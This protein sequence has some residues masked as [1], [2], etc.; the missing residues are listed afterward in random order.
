MEGDG[1]AFALPLVA[2]PEFEE[3]DGPAFE[4][5]LAVFGVNDTDDFEDGGGAFFV[6]DGGPFHSIED[7]VGHE[8]GFVGLLVGLGPELGGG[9]LI[10]DGGEGGD[11]AG[12]GEAGGFHPAEPRAEVVFV[13]AR[14][15]AEAAGGIAVHGGVSNGSFGAIGGGEEEGVTKVGK[16]PDAG[17]ADAGLDILAGDV[18]FFPGELTAKYGFDRP[19]VGFDE[20][21]DFPLGV[22]A[23]EGFGDGA[24]GLA[25][26]VATV[27]GALVGAEEEELH[28][29]VC[30]LGK[31][32]VGKAFANLGFTKFCEGEVEH[33]FGEAGDGRGVGTAT[34]GDDEA[35]GPGFAKVV[36]VG[37]GH[38]AGEFLVLGHGRDGLVAIPAGDLG[39]VEI[40][41]D[42]GEAADVDLAAHGAGLVEAVAFDIDGA[43]RESGF[44]E[45]EAGAFGD[46]ASG[47]GDESAA[48]VDGAS[49]FVAEEVGVNVGGT[50]SAGAF[51]NELFADFLF[52]EGEVGGAGV[53]DD[54]DSAAG[55][56][57]AGAVGDP[58]V[59]TDFEANADAADFENGISDGEVVI[60]E[61][62]LDDDAFGPGVEPTGFVV[63]AVSC[64]VFLSDETADGAIDKDGDGVVN[65]VFDPDREADG[66]DHALGFW[67]DLSEAGPSALG[68]FVGEELVL[69]AIAGD[70]EFGQA[71]DG[72]V[73]FAGVGDALK[74]AAAVA[75]PVHGNLVEAACAYSDGVSHG[76]G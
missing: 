4:L 59:F 20:G 56:E 51:D 66:D 8:V 73:S 55:E 69:A 62:V 58:G 33:D 10:V 76:L 46:D 31:V 43:D 12:L 5:F 50:K 1:V 48:V 7:G 47:G 26:D 21:V 71:K 14:D 18:V 40:K 22:V 24:G 32:E 75:A 42:F 3:F 45:G 35:A 49:G 15:G 29:V 16:H 68:E 37:E 38:G 2:A 36:E 53:E 74:D 30:L 61:F 70:G 41:F 27:F 25:G 19:F 67:G 52:P 23:A 64:E 54:I 72:D 65:G 17:G 9:L 57:A 60:A 63:E 28:P 34:E 13:D 6:A 39:P 44:L 11:G